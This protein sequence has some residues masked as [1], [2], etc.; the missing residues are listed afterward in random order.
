[1]GSAES[2]DYD[3]VLD[4][5]LVGPVPGGRHMFVFQVSRMIGENFGGSQDF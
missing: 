4:S 3:Q 1:M 5:V 2:M